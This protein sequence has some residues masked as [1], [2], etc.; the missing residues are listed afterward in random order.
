MSVE[1][2]PLHVKGAKGR[3]VNSSTSSGTFLKETSYSPTLTLEAL[4]VHI[5]RTSRGHRLPCGRILLHPFFV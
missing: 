1:P 4:L 5:V 3:L 2:G